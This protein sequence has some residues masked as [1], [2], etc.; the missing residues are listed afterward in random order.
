MQNLKLF[1]VFVVRMFLIFDTLSPTI[2]WYYK[3]IKYGTKLIF[4][5]YSILASKLKLCIEPEGII[6]L[7]K[8]FMKHLDEYPVQSKTT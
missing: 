8:Y 4:Y 5:L 2:I 3:L 7:Y 1:Y 6:V